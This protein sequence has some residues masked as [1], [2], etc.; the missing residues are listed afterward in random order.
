MP[1]NIKDTLHYIEEKQSKEQRDGSG[2]EKHTTNAPLLAFAVPDGFIGEVECQATNFPLMVKNY[3]S[4]LL[5]HLCFVLPKTCEL[6]QKLVTRLLG[7]PRL[8]KLTFMQAKTR[9]EDTKRC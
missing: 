2:L 3:D 8:Q 4:G 5:N 7:T 9:T 1:P 6:L